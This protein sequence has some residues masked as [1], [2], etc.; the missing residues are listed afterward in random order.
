MSIGGTLIDPGGGKERILKS[1]SGKNATNPSIPLFILCPSVIVN[2]R[3]KVFY[4]IRFF[5]FSSVYPFA[6]PYAPSPPS[7]PMHTFHKKSRENLRGGGG[8]LNSIKN[9]LLFAS[10]LLTKTM[11]A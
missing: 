10:S 4:K 5:H 8:F 3:W 6:H 11:P 2:S 1:I 7:P 9:F